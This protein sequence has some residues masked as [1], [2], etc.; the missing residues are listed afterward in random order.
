MQKHSQLVN[1]RRLIWKGVFINIILATSGDRNP[2]GKMNIK[3]GSY[4]IFHRVLVVIHIFA[5][6][7]K[8]SFSTDL[9][10]FINVT[11][12]ASTLK[13]PEIIAMVKLVVFDCLPM[14]K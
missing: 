4:V 14:M 8:V 9:Y 13:F 2:V 6:L 11:S 10:A 1:G 5:E 7:F 3:G 12:K